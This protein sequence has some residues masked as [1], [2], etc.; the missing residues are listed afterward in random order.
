MS[1]SNAMTT[2]MKSLA[3]VLSDL[4]TQYENDA[5]YWVMLDDGRRA[6]DIQ[7]VLVNEPELFQGIVI[8]DQVLA[9][10]ATWLE[11]TYMLDTSEPEASAAWLF[12]TSLESYGKNGEK[13]SVLMY[14]GFSKL[15]VVEQD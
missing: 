10:Q 3:E 14:H 13:P 7:Y 8:E 11:N 12:M 15:E 6:K 4:Q 5:N 9:F 2:N 1:E